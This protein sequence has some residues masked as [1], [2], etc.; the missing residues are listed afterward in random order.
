MALLDFF[1]KKKKEVKKAGKKKEEIKKKEPEPQ[2]EEKISAVPKRKITGIASSVL[3]S[4][5]VTEKATNLTNSG[6]YIFNVFPKVSKPQIKRA[7]EEVY[8]VEVAKVRTINI[9]GQEKR[10]GRN[11]GWQKGSRK[12]I[13]NLKKGYKIEI[14]P[15]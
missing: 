2:K 11:M 12:A 13:V 1:K 7:I 8:G 14:M 9:K 3:K 15:R 5:H 6:Q 10:F 4:P